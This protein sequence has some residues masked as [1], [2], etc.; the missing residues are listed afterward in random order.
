MDD[1]MKLAAGAMLRKAA[2]REALQLAKWV[3]V[4]IQLSAGK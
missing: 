3:R 4:R 1:E 2:T